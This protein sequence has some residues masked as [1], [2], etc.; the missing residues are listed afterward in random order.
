M[1]SRSSCV[2]C[3]TRPTTVEHLFPQWLG[4][5]L[6]RQRTVSQLGAGDADG[7]DIYHTFTGMSYVAKGKVV[8]KGCNGGWMKG[9]EDGASPVIKRMFDEKIAIGIP[10]GSDPTRVTLA[11]WAF[12]TAIMLQFQARGSVIPLSVY[13]EFYVTKRPPTSCVVYLAH[14]TVGRTSCGHH[15]IK[16][17]VSAPIPSSLGGQYEGDMYAITFFVKNVVLQVVGYHPSL[18]DPFGFRV[19]FPQTFAKYVQRLWP[20]GYAVQWPVGRSLS[21]AQLFTFGTELTKIGT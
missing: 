18:P 19:G 13:R 4:R 10:A 7:I 5:Y 11:A 15:S 2:F 16:W 20:S 8:C 12:K 14:H 9:L 3:G 1:L 17:A 6:G 21:D